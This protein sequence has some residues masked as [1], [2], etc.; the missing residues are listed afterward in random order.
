MKGNVYEDKDFAD[1]VDDNGNVVGR[2]PKS[3]KG[4]GLLQAGHSIK[5]GRAS[6]P[7]PD[8]ASPGE[9]EVPA[10]SET[11]DVLEAYAVAHGMSQEQAEGYPNKGELHTAIVAAAAGS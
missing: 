6:K 5:G 7:A 10:E 3:W 1:V 2:A 11:R 4:T 9:S 8:P